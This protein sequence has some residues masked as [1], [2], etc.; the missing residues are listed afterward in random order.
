MHYATIAML[1]IK[2]N[3]SRKNRFEK[4]YIYQTVD[5]Y[6]KI[7]LN[8]IIILCVFKSRQVS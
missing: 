6:L 8:Q 5:I 1:P 7:Q 4:F 2:E 3:E